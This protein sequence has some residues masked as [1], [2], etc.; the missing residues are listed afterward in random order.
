MVADALSRYAYPA[1]R[2]LQDC[3]WHGSIEDSEEMKKILEDEV[4]EDEEDL[5]RQE[6]S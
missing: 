2:A 5:I 4:E 1:S 3:S 6:L